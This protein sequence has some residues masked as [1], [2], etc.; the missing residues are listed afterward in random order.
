MDGSTEPRG[1]EALGSE[2][3]GS[4][5]LGPE[6][7]G[8]EPGRP[9]AEPR[10]ELRLAPA[11]PTLRG[12]ADADPGL[13]EE[14]VEI[15]L[16]IAGCASIILT[17]EAQRD[18]QGRFRLTWPL[19]LSL[20]DGLPREARAFHMAS[21][22]ELEGSPLTLLAPPPADSTQRDDTELLDA[23][24]TGLRWTEGLAGSC[25]ATLLS[26]LAEGV[27]VQAASPARMLRFEHLA[28]LS[29]SGGLPQRGVRV[30][31]DEEASSV[32][33]HMRLGD[34]V[35]DR[36]EPWLITAWLPEA[37]EAQL[38]LRLDITLECREEKG[39]RPLRRLRRGTLFRRPSL[40]SIELLL[41]AEE[42]E[43]LAAGGVWLAL[44]A[45]QA[46]GLSV[47]LPERRPTER[48]LPERLL[49]GPPTSTLPPAS[50]FEDA[51][52]EGAFTHA[53]ELLRVHGEAGA[54]GHAML[55]GL[56]SPPPAGRSRSRLSAA[57]A[58]P[59]T[60]IILPIY[61]GSEEVRQCLHA[62]R[63]AATG[64]MQVLMVDDGSRDFTTEMLRAEAALDPRFILHR[65]DV[66]RG[67][68]KSIN[69]GVM[70][71]GA[72]WVVVL[73]SDTIVP[74]GWLDRL[75]AAAAAR[76]GTGMVGPLSNAATW[77]SLPA[78][79]RPDG[80]WSTNE[81]IEPRHLAQVQA[82]LNAISECDY[83][84]F[85][86]LNGFCTMIARRVFDTV[87]L[88]DEDAFP[89]GYGE[90][91]DLCL[92]ARRAGFRLT[93]ADDCFV[94][95]HK[96]VSFGSA[97]RL[98]LSRAGGLEMTNKHSGVIIPALERMMQDCAPMGRLRA[99]FSDLAS[100]LN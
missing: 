47:L 68:T 45:H 92:R 1:S 86:V 26:Q 69:E 36:P 79:K 29:A 73:N 17:S 2:A 19:P 50:R 74:H 28:E 49:V 31:A 94:Y 16:D 41:S 83:P 27:L 53:V 56:W 81:M 100:E 97:A 32:T 8:A 22:L 6:P 14:R 82:L 84:E 64:P 93:I 46:K 24:G 70:L 59:F 98:R 62:L 96:S 9:E 52:L 57:G 11:P 18:A 30:L 13:P 95:H 44:K 58:H 33:L 4:A 60:Q 42:A 88:Y 65:R 63:A 48:L 7:F 76:P 34:A 87:G 61:N 51:R 40:H 72:E 23:S 21:G 35:P 15:G 66:N 80:S 12:W 75:H 20:R 91:V 38:Q 37:T 99:R 67:Y 78:A 25:P 43:Q 90:E 39:F 55:P 3:L 89:L 10:G 85:A 71:T 77:Q 54:E 5:A